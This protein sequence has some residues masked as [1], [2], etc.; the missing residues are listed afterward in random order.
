[1]AH[2]SNI[3]LTLDQNQQPE[4][5]AL[6]PSVEIHRLLNQNPRGTDIMAS[7]TEAELARN[8]SKRAG[9]DTTAT[10]VNSANAQTYEAP[11]VAAVLQTN[12]LLHLIISELTRECR[13]SV[14]RV[15]R[16]WQAA[17]E[18]IGH[19]FEPLR[20]ESSSDSDSSSEE[21]DTESGEDDQVEGSATAVDAVLQ[22]YE[23]LHLI[24]GEV[25]LK[26]RTSIRRVA[27]AWKAAVAKIGYTLQP[28]AQDRTNVPIYSSSQTLVTNDANLLINCLQKYGPMTDPIVHCFQLKPCHPSGFSKI[29][30]REA[31]FLTDPP[32]T[33]AKLE[34]IGNM[35]TAKATILRVNEGIRIEHVKECFARMG[36]SERRWGKHAY[37]AVQR[38]EH[39]ESN[40]SVGTVSSSE[41]DDSSESGDSDHSDH[42]DDSYDSDASNS[43]AGGAGMPDFGEP[44]DSDGEN[45]SEHD[46]AGGSSDSGDCS[47]VGDSK[48]DEDHQVEESSAAAVLDTNELLHMI[49]SEVPREHRVSLRR[50]SKN[51]QAAI[52]KIGYVFQPADHSPRY[53]QDDPRPLYVSQ[54]I[55][56]SNP[57]FH[58]RLSSMGRPANLASPGY[59]IECRYL[60]SSRSVPHWVSVAKLKEN[61]HQFITDPPLTELQ[62]RTGGILVPKVRLQVDG[63]IRLKDL[64]EFVQT[65]HRRG[66]PNFFHACFGG[67]KDFSLSKPDEESG[68]SNFDES[69][70]GARVDE[71]ADPSAS[72]APVDESEGGGGPN[73][74]EADGDES[75]DSS[76]PDGSSEKEDGDADAADQERAS[77]QVL[78]AN[79]LLHMIISEVPREFRTSM[80]RVSKNWQAA[81]VKLGFAVEPIDHEA[82]NRTRYC[83]TPLYP[84]EL[85]F[86]PNPAL[87]SK[88]SWIHTGPRTTVAANTRVYC[89]HLSFQP[90]DL[91]TK[92]EKL[93]HE[94]ITDPPITQARMCSG[95]LVPEVLLQVRGGIKIRDLLECF[96]ETRDNDPSVS[97]T[98]KFGGLKECAEAIDC[99]SPTSEEAESSDLDDYQWYESSE[100][101]YTDD[102]AEGPSG[103][104][105]EERQDVEDVGV[106][107][108]NDT[109]ATD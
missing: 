14:R 10:P 18:K 91:A 57:V 97:I 15:S 62:V 23:L 88:P 21:G 67:P 85:T 38:K 4:A 31:E 68:E 17:V 83:V 105:D 43:G 79:E 93:E 66:G 39:G 56:K 48:P 69:E 86:K 107:A 32:V 34:F 3:D 53:H 101:E 104:G 11:A 51:W 24:I 25:P 1:M 63:G 40:G 12:E 76:P 49:F 92:L 9:E 81:V 36:L 82:A 20:E 5:N 61:G 47:E 33:Q 13:N 54:T 46:D 19:V 7:S 102:E 94:F 2:S 55:F 28:V 30:E 90:V 70:D 75:A 64:L 84:P 99:F 26:H 65:A 59:R 41:E 95:W 16:A 100:Y 96:P 29:A 45:L 77:S 52:E 71:S 98:A 58:D 87:V 72:D 78:H 37:I 106:E 22:T 80:R 74:S 44:G 89:Q 60:E 35:S 50:V 103:P 109:I 42:S 8:Q 6:P 73:E 27:K 108:A